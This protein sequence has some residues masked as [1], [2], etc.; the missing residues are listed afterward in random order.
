[1]A[2]GYEVSK[3]V[4]DSK[5]AQALLQLR[6]AFENVEAVS[7]FLANNPSDG[8][9]EPLVTVYGYTVDEAYSLRLVF[10]TFETIRINSLPTFEIARKV[11]GLE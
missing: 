9:V 3:P 1:M 2:L 8:Q 6:E 10:E 4:L 11:T 7:K 5:A